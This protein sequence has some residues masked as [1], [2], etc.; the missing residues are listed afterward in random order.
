MDQDLKQALLQLSI[1]SAKTD[2]QL[3]KTDAQ[4]AKTDAQLA[5]TDAQLARTDAQ[6]AKND[7]KIAKAIASIEKLSVEIRGYIG[8]DSQSV[9]EYFY[10]TLAKK[11]RL[12]DTQY[13]EIGRNV[14]LNA[15]SPEFDIVLYNG[16]TIGLVEVKKKAHPDDLESMAENKIKAFKKMLPHYADHRFYFGVATMVSYAD[17]ITLAKE[18]GIFLLTQQGDELA[19]LNDEVRVF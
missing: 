4:L 16:D 15:N 13:D 6:I 19:Y 17:L 7:A 8:N 2:A 5:E 9:E 14:R 10:Q 12:G 1:Q 3:A 11:M 18:Q